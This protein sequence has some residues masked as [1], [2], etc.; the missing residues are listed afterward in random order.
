[1]MTV[2]RILATFLVLFQVCAWLPAQG[3]RPV[4]YPIFA[5]PA[6]QRAVQQGT[7][8]EDGLPGTKYFTNRASYHIEAELEPTT[9]MVRGRIQIRYTNRAP[10]A[11]RRLQ[12]HLRQNLHKQGSVRNRF[13][14]ITGGMEVENIK[15]AGQDLGVG[16]RG[17]RLAGTVLSVP[18]RQ[19]LRTGES[20][21]LSMDF[22]YRVPKRGAPRN[23]HEDNHV[24]YLAYWYP[25]V[26]VYDDVRGWVAEQYMSNS[27]FYMGYG[28]Y[29]IDFTAPQ[30]WLVRCS[31]ALLNPQEVLTK[32]AQERLAK[33]AA[34]RE[35]IQV[36]D[37]EDLEQGRVTAKAESG[38]LTWRFEA[39]N[40]RDVAVSVSD[41]YVWDATHAVVKDKHGPGKDGKAMIH[42]VYRP[43]PLYRSFRS[44][45]RYGQH[46][47]EYMSKLVFPYPWP[48]MTA[49]EGIIGGGMEFPM[50]T[51]IGGRS[52]SVLGVTCHEIIHMWFPMIVGS[53]EKRHAWMDEGMTSF[54][55]SRCVAAFR[56]QGQPQRMDMAS[57]RRIAA[58]GE[59]IPVM[60]H[61][62]RYGAESRSAYGINSYTKTSAV[63]HQL[64]LL[65]GTETFDGVIREYV[66]TWQYKHPY[67]RDLFRSFKRVSGQDL[68][69][70]FRIWLYETWSLD[71]GVKAVRQ[72]E[73]GGYEVV[74]EDR[75]LGMHPTEVRVLLDAGDGESEAVT[76]KIPI[77]EWLQ[78]KREV[79]LRFDRPVLEV[80]VDPR[81]QTLDIS[82]R[83]NKWTKGN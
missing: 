65:L 35:V 47:V 72:A 60:R 81:Q 83:N 52:R 55:T 19:R 36:I 50:M 75:Q 40:V 58:M 26:A 61:G 62:D 10:R 7:R 48:H 68:D 46:T 44:A 22:R 18:L 23:G 66:R 9:A 77:S 63:L 71:T 59:E 80:E 34:S 79:V 14:E 39:E 56:E 67:P 45:A 41:R 16:R 30:G 5:S 64:R 2:L 29:R 15:V 74:I 42:A 24:F 3:Q 25:Q 4:P 37:A 73:G 57:Y 1:M 69:W 78:G 33:A 82:R 70:Y 49:C 13:V 51:I 17:A 43:G 11:L 6:W 28:D 21:E 31:G 8:T 53:D 12:V 20:V 54:W 32:T 76:R 27:E 38:K